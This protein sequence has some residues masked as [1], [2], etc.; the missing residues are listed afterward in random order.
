MTSSCS[1]SKLTP[2][3]FYLVST[4]RVRQAVLKAPDSPCCLRSH[5]RLPTGCVLRRVFG[6]NDWEDL[7][8]VP[9]HL[10]HGAPSGRTLEHG[11]HLTANDR[12]LSQWLATPKLRI[13]IL[14]ADAVV[15]EA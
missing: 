2:L 3:A 6:E 12:P 4:V 8:R 11:F 15:M 14:S 13:L 1:V 7:S 10:K 5:L 9:V